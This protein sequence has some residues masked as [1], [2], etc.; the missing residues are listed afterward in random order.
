MAFTPETLALVAVT[1]DDADVRH[2]G[3]AALVARMVA[4]GVTAV[5][6]REKSLTDDAFVEEA[7][8]VREVCARDGAA[9]LLNERIEHAAALSPDAV[10][11]THRSCGVS[12]ARTI[13][14]DV[15][16]GISTHAVAE[17][18]H[19]AAEG[20]DYIVC[21]PVFDTPSK[22]G[23][24]QPRGLESL[25]ELAPLPVPV[26]AIGG[27]DEQTAGQARAVGASGVAVIRA[28]FAADDPAEAAR[29]LKGAA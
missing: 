1:P 22:R 27:I 4:G 19:R 24:L 20:A 16:L 23:L 7:S 14:G 2:H 26:I 9:F 10:H 13:L 29:R 15:A 8:R 17:A 28:L 11:L 6:F 25:G 3:L 5:M 12:E 18:R 21:G